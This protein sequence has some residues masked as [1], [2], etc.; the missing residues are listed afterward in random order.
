[1]TPRCECGRPRATGLPACRRCAALD[2]ISN[3]GAC[4]TTDIIS[5]LRSVGGCG[6]IETIEVETRMLAAT[7]QTTLVRLRKRGRVI[8]RRLPVAMDG[9]GCDEV[10]LW[11]LVSPPELAEVA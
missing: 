6:T 10:G 2:G 9:Y 5:A 7:I 3:R 8:A 4:G 11:I 1:M